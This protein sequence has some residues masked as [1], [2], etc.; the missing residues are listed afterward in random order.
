VDK[1]IT[2]KGKKLVKFDIEK[3]DFNADC[4]C[5]DGCCEDIPCELPSCWD[6]KSGLKWKWRIVD[7]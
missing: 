7:E 4:T 6:D 5:C 3:N 1:I 2:H